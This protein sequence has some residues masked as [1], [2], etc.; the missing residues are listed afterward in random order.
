MLNSFEDRLITTQEVL[1][2][3]KKETIDYCQDTQDSGRKTENKQR[4]V[5]SIGGPI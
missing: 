1:H 2:Y 5:P 4:N 3:G